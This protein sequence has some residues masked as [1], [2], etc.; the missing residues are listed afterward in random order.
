MRYFL[1]LTNLLALVAPAQFHRITAPPAWV[2]NTSLE[3]VVLQDTS[4]SRGG[5]EYLLVD[6]QY[7]HG[8]R[9]MPAI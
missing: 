2:Q 9:T 6:R 1:L 4:C 3:G 8:V 5:T 7:N